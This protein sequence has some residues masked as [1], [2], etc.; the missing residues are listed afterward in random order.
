MR[1]GKE[2]DVCGAAVLLKRV[3]FLFKEAAAYRR[4]VSYS[5]TS[6]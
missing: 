6:E 5:M 2:T 3:G 1:V 4:Q